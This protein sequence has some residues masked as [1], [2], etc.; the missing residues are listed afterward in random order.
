MKKIALDLD[1]VVFDSE[2]LYRVYAEMHDVDKFKCD[3]LVD[4][5]PRRFQERYNWSEEEFKLFYK[6]SASIVL[7]QANLMTGVEVI[8]KKLI[9]KFE[10]II[11]TARNDEEVSIAMEKLNKIGLT[12]ISI[13]NNEH[14]K[15]DRLLT[16]KCDYIV[17][18]DETICRQAA[19]NGINGIYFKNAAS[20]L[21][22]DTKNFKVVNNWGEIYKY[23][24][25]DGNN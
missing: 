20:K 2:N 16:E 17:D 9:D 18:D 10:I 22:E 5:S 23:L 14:S 21:V 12:N 7:S 1:G 25:L 24:I 6:E 19:E 13:F 11:V 8:L 3:N 15:V 4:N